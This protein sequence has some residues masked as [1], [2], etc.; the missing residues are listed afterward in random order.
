MSLNIA[1]SDASTYNE[2]ISH[3][4]DARTYGIHIRYSEVTLGEGVRSD[5]LLQQ[6]LLLICRISPLISEL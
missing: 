5:D 4:R 1:R 6:N 3:D 2:C